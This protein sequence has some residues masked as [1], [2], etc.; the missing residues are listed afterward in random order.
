MK[1]KSRDFLV[2]EGCKVRLDR[3]PTIIHP[4]YRSKAHYEE[5]LEDHIKRLTE[6][7]TLLYASNRYA[8]LVIFQAMDAAGK[9]SAIK[10]VMSGVNPQGCRVFAFKPPTRIELQHD[11]LWRA[12]CNLP[13]RGQIGIF[14]R[15]HY[16]DV[17]VPRVHPERLRD[18]GFANDPHGR[19]SILRDRYRSIAAFER[20]LH[21]NQTRI[22][23]F[24]LH[25]SKDEQRKRLIARI[26]D[27]KKN[28]KLDIADIKER[29]FW[30]GYVKAYDKCLSATSTRESP[31]FIVPADDKHN[32]RLIVSHILLDRF[33]G[34]NMAYPRAS[35]QELLAIRGQLA[36]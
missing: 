12:A 34:L 10:H 13:E 20:H 15:S 32:A 14:N 16:E 33:E 31:W 17:L 35:R 19:Q 5:I 24:Y 4:A 8:L 23:K 9:D 22:V 3:W 2:R 26:D 36:E 18:E 1:I 6:L 11:F 27:P 21:A 29:K 30:R 28:W 7:Q 25:I